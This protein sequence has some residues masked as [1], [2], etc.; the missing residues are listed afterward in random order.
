MNFSA[1]QVKLLRNICALLCAVLLVI[2]PNV[3]GAI[4][5]NQHTMQTSVAAPAVSPEGASQP[6]PQVQLFD[7]QQ[8]RIVKTLPNT[9]AVQAEAAK[10]LQSV[11]GLS[12]Q[13]NIGSK[14]GYIVRIALANP[15]QVKL[16]RIDFQTNDVFLIYCPDKK[17]LLLVFT[18]ERKPFLLEFK[19][20]VQP[21]ME[22]LMKPMLPGAEQQ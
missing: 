8:E 22:E 16:P 7:M 3:A 20:N 2:M 1:T 10:W 21:F 13:L 5:K 4:P 14:C 9:P 17:P 18:P 6:L 12:P 19:H 11:T 15:F